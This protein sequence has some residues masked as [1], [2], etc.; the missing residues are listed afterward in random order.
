MID[1]R[2]WL[3][4]Y[5]VAELVAVELHE[6]RREPSIGWADR[7]TSAGGELRDLLLIVRRA[8]AGRAGLDAGELTA[9]LSRTI[10]AARA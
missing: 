3:E 7:P 8:I 9:R 2:S 1:S 10:A 4:A 5:V 6:P